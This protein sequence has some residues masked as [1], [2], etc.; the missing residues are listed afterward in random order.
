MAAFLGI[1]NLYI[2]SSFFPLCGPSRNIMSICRGDFDGSTVKDSF[3][4]GTFIPVQVISFPLMVQRHFDQL[5]G[6]SL[7]RSGH[8]SE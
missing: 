5:M 4:S 6:G 2:P 3:T 8:Q 1:V 7:I